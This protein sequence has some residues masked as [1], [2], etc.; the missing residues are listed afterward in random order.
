MFDGESDFMKDV[1][2]LMQT[3]LKGDHITFLNSVAEVATHNQ[4]SV[5]VVGGFVRDLLLNIKNV[6]IDLVV[7]GNGIVFAEKLAEKFSGRT[8]TH[9]K[10]GTATLMLQGRPSIDVATARTE[11]YSCPA[12][13]PDV[14]PSSIKQDLARRDFTVNSMAVKLS[15]RGTFYLID[16]FGGEIDLKDGLIRVLH[17]QSFVDDPCR[18]F[19]AIRFE[20][21]LEFCVNGPTK[22]LMRSAIEN[23]LIDQLSGDRL[24]N[25]M[26][27][28]LSEADPVR[29]VDRM[30]EL[31]LFQAIAPEILD[32]DFHWT[33]MNKIHSTLAWADMIPMTTKPEAWFIYFYTLFMITD[34][35]VFKRMMMRLNF[36]GNIYGRMCS[37][38]ECFVEAMND[39]SEERE[40]KPSEIY[41]I[42]SKQSSEVVILMLAACPNKRMKEYVELY[43]KKY[44]ASAKIELNG[45]DL[46]GM[47]MEPGA[48]FKDVFKALRDARINGQ[49]TSRDEEIDLVESLFLK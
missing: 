9:K 46:I 16:L 8:S 22:Q 19:R 10:F 14:E 40:L 15:G 2:S 12:A 17:D 41:N 6:D 44:C 33:I 18:L 25:E 7:E 34:D 37:D 1:S 48:S 35:N 5:Y 24:M 32:D 49:V 23:N 28:L 27:I 47:G 29:C 39:F 42:F 31:L 4:M 11:S 3:R 45:D 43:F 30:R 20:Q 36:P 26:K 38:R 13:L 21:R